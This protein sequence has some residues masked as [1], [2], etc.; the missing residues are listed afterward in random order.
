MDDHCKLID[1]HVDI[2]NHVVY[3]AKILSDDSASFID[4]V[5][6]ALE[7]YATHCSERTPGD[8]DPEA[9]AIL[10]QNLETNPS[11]PIKQIQK[12]TKTLQ[13]G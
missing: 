1:I 4:T 9:P 11:R 3:R 13:W 7:E 2:G 6:E 12:E 10:H 8:N 5:T